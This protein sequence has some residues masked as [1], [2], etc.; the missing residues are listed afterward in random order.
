MKRIILLL[1]LITA[2]LSGFSQG[3]K[4]I[5]VPSGGSIYTTDAVAT[6][7]IRPGDTLLLNESVSQM[8]L[9]GLRGTEDS[10]IVVMASGPDVTIGKGSNRNVETPFPY[11]VKF[12]NLTINGGTTH[13]T[14]WLMVGPNF[15]T[16]ENVSIDSVGIGLQ[17]KRFPDTTDQNTTYPK[18]NMR[19]IKL[20]NIRVTNSDNEGFYLGSTMSA[21]QEGSTRPNTQPAMIMGLWV[22]SLYG[23]NNGWD[24]VQITDAFNVVGTRFISDSAGIKN[25]S[26][27][28]SGITIQDAA[29]GIF[30]SLTSNYSVAAGLNIFAQGILKITNV[31]IKKAADS[32]HSYA[33]FVDNRGSHGLPFY[34]PRTLLVSNMDIGAGNHVTAFG[35]LQSLNGGAYTPALTGKIVNLTTVSGNKSDAVPNTYFGGTFGTPFTETSDSIVLYDNGTIDTFHVQGTVDLIAP[36]AAPMFFYVKNTSNG[37]RLKWNACLNNG[38]SPIL[39]YKIYKGRTAGGATTLLTTVSKDSLGYTDLAVT[40]DSTYSYVV[41]AYN[42][43]Y[44]SYNP[45]NIINEYLIT[46]NQIGA[47]ATPLTVT[48]AGTPSNN[49]VVLSWSPADPR[50]SA[51]TAYNIYR[52]LSGG[53]RSLVGSVNGS[54]LTYV[55]GGL[56]NGTAYDYDV[57][58]VNGIGTANPS[59]ILTLTPT[60]AG[61]PSAPQSV[62][63]TP[64]TGQ[65]TITWTA[66]ITDGG[67][68]ITSYQILRGTVPGG[69][70][71]SIGTVSGSTFIKVDNSRPAGTV[72]YYMVRAI[73]AN[74]NGALSTEVSAAAN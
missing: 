13:K 74:G 56:T 2:F 31:K 29:S 49:S 26:A 12:I 60:S 52:G 28:S 30:D 69:A 25:V 67:S 42:A 53:S 21:G 22:D 14:G 71:N 64:G 62:A 7:N 39:G 15:V 6:W 70:K 16:V 36:P 47:P 33:V 45:A 18:A 23:K 51:L 8:Y 11:G 44:E 1:T 59:N 46:Y 61:V 48:L 32:S 24:C 20:K 54:T 72:Y 43:S 40:Q 10:N 38:G 41:T 58:A 27:Q 4:I 37:V 19:N 34:Y 50:N 9:G 63:A 5:M 35:N 3:R 57:R 17:I 65:I 55:D 73:N 68:S 66:P